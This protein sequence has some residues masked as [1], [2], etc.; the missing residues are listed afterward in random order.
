MKAEKVSQWSPTLDDYRELFQKVPCY[1]SVQNRD[2]R[3]VVT[4]ELFREDFGEREGELCYEVYNKRDR[5]CR[6]CPVQKAFETGEVY[7]SEEYVVTRDGKEV[8]V[9]VYT[10]PIRNHEGEIIEVMEMITNITYY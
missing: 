8:I 5:P 4:N 7:T 9:V 3:I 2:L 6:D 1:I 10:S